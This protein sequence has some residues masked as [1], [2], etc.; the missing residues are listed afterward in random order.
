MKANSNNMNTLTMLQQ[1]W[2]CLINENN[3][4]QKTPGPHW[5]SGEVLHFPFHILSKATKPP[6][7]TRA[8]S[9]MSWFKFR[10]SPHNIINE[11]KIFIPD[12]ITENTVFIT[13]R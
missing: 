5:V 2:T 10:S 7:K 4:K 12:A 9:R 11:I 1:K 6:L 3:I 8:S 13:Y